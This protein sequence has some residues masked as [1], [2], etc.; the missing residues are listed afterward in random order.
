MTR[1]KTG[2]D[3]VYFSFEDAKELDFRN[4]ISD[5]LLK[6]EKMVNSLL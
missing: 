4:D 5:E 6:V 3:G 2:E 1:E